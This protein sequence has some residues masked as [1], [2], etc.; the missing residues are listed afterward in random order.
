LIRENYSQLNQDLYVLDHYP[1][2]GYFVEIGAG[3]PRYLSNTKLLEEKGWTGICVDPL[4]DLDLFKKH[5]RKAIV[6]KKAVYVN[7][8]I[9]DFSHVCS[10]NEISTLTDYLMIED[11]H[12]ES[13]SLNNQIKIECVLLRDLL[14][15]HKSP[16]FIEYLSIDTE[17]SELDI[18]KAYDWS[19]LFGI[20]TI[21]HNYRKGYLEDII[22]L[23]KPHGYNE[24]KSVLFDAWFIHDSL[25][26]VVDQ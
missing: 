6:D 22:E 14:N 13:R 4:L 18:L 20:I 19:R 7:N 24:Y 15:H 1:N 12:V 3:H 25:T 21:E 11:N 16:M 23:L 26:F 9:V 17:G 10:L 2:G 5:N 8:S